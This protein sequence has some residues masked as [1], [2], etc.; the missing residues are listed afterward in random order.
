[1]GVCEQGLAH[2]Y[3]KV[4]TKAKR[5]EMAAAQYRE[6]F[7]ALMVE[8]CRDFGSKLIK[9]WDSNAP[10]DEICEF[11]EEAVKN[12]FIVAK[13]KRGGKTKADPPVAVAVVVESP[14]GLT[15]IEEEAPKKKAPVTKKKK[16]GKGGYGIYKK[17]EASRVVTEP[18]PKTEK[19][20]KPKCQAV[21][22]KGTPCSK[23]ALDGGIFCA[24]HVKS[25]EDKPKK[26]SSVKEVVELCESHGDEVELPDTDNDAKDPT[27]ELEE[28][29]FDEL[30]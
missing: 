3:K 8:V 9:S 30:D 21:T 17:A 7:E 23:C 13:K 26:K 19:K 10:K 25:K 27:Y 28:E 24:V 1:M 16:K 5:G 4:R 22:A 15:D 18:E 20:S 12:F 14:S 11:V 6:Q 2:A 29:D